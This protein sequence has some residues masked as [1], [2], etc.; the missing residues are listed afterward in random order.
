MLERISSVTSE[1]QAQ[2][3][4]VIEIATSKPINHSLFD[5]IKNTPKF[6]YIIIEKIGSQYNK[7]IEKIGSQYNKL[8]DTKTRV[9]LFVLRLE[10]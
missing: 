4:N 5:L 3:D 1:N 9:F 2:P 7:I 8:S 10:I 6:I